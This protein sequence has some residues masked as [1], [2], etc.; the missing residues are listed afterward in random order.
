MRQKGMNSENV[1]FHLFG[2]AKSVV[3]KSS[4]TLKEQMKTRADEHF[5]AL[6]RIIP[7]VTRLMLF[8][9]AESTQRSAG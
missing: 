1:L 9:Y 4:K 8:E 3:K 6:K 5:A 7:T 2:S